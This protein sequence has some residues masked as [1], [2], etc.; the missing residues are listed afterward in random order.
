MFCYFVFWLPVFKDV[1]TPSPF[2]EKFPDVEGEGAKAALQDHIYMD[3]MGFG[4]GMCCLQVH[5]LLTNA[6][7]CESNNIAVRGDNKLHV[8]AKENMCQTRE[9]M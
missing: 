9:N 5:V 7:I 8:N 6:S 4:M 1:N 3:S 2:I